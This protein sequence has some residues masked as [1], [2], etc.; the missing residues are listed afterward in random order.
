MSLT[1]LLETVYVDAEFY[2]TVLFLIGFIAF[3]GTILRYIYLTNAYKKL[4]K[5]LS[6]QINQSEESQIRIFNI[7]DHLE[8]KKTTTPKVIIRSWQRFYT[9]YNN[10]SNNTIPDPL[11]YF[12]ENE[13]VNKAGFRKLVEIVPAIFVSLGILGTFMGITIGIS[14]I[15]TGADVQGIQTGINTL[16]SGMHFAFFSSI[17]GILLSLIYQFCDRV[18]F[19][20]PIINSTDKLLSVLD[21]TIPVETE[22]SL[23]DKMA[24]TQEEQLNTMRDFFTDEL[25]PQLTSGISESVSKSMAPHLEKSN[26]IMDQVAKN[27]LDAQSDSLNQMVDHFVESLNEV[28]GNQMSKLG[29]ALHKTVEW[30]EKVH[31]EM[32]NLVDELSHVAKEQSEMAKNTTELSKQMNEYTEKLSNYQDRLSATVQELDSITE[33]NTQLL[34]QMGET[35]KSLTLRQQETEEAFDQKITNMNTAIEKMTGLGSTFNDLNE[36]MNSTLTSL[37]D[38]TGNVNENIEQNRKLNESLIKQHELSNEWSTKTHEILEDMAHNSNLSESIQKNLEDLYS[39][40]SSERTSLDKMQSNYS[41]TLTTSVHELSEVWKEQ[42]TIWR[43]TE[44]QFTKLNEDLTNS[45]DQFA[46]HM[47]RGIQGT[48]ELFD[49]QLKNA[50]GYLAQGVSSIESV[51]ESM[52]EDIGSVNGQINRFNEYL[53]RFNTEEK[54]G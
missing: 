53:K 47:H 32:S 38:T 24:N 43:N 22:S 50:I 44:D 28:T 26:E 1:E 39:A 6:G 21:E 18:L 3:L 37:I 27:T 41:Q 5:F 48:F 19:Y 9:E 30:Q 13:L 15:N 14:D 51:V 36:E 8:K 33:T 54:I 34:G 42:R 7:N 20:R 25:I 2:I 11:F 46:E 16:L 52:E 49:G 10:T 23:L 4:R 29:D 45:M 17:I 35:M 40:I 31:G 12:N